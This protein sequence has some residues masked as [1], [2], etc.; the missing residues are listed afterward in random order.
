[1][2]GPGR[3]FVGLAL[4]VGASV[5]GGC[6]WNAAG[7]TGCRPA[8]PPVALPEVLHES[9][10]AAWS[11][12]RPGAFWTH[13]DGSDSTLHALDEDATL[14]SRVRVTGARLRDLEDMATGA[15][16]LGSCIYLADTGDNQEVRPQIQILRLQEPDPT[17]G[18]SAEAQVFPMVLPHGPR[19]IEALFVLPGE[20]VYLVTKGRNHPNTLYRYPP[21]LRSGEVVTLEEVQTLSD[22]SMPILAQVTGADATPDGRLVAVRTYQELRFYRVDGGRLTLLEGGSVALRTLQEPQGEGVALGPDHRVILTTE[23]GNFGGVAAMRILECNLPRDPGT[24]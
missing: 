18:G 8:G 20:E 6:P 17:T 23:A 22:G 1:M 19:D 14:L 5:I 11:L 4:V 16:D 13:N 12:I 2:M 7:N 10:G 9:S 15:C 21:P 24:P 3:G